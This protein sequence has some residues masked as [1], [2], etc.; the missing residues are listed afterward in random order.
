MI[1]GAARGTGVPVSVTFSDSETMRPPGGRRPW[2]AVRSHGADP[3][4][5]Y[6]TRTGVSSIS[7]LAGSCAARSVVMRR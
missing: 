2:S 5:M 1:A 7:W 6:S 3:G 4:G